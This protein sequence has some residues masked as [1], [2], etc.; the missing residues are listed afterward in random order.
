MRT[1]SP[2]WC[3][4]DRTHLWPT[5]SSL[6]DPL[7]TARNFSSC[8]SDSISRW[9]P[10]PPESASGGFRSALA[11]SDFRLR[12][13]LDVSIPSTSPASEAF[14]PAFGYSAPHP[15]TGGTSTLLINALLSAHHGSICDSRPSAFSGYPRHL[16]K[17]CQ[18]FFDRPSDISTK[19]PQGFHMFSPELQEHSA[20][21]RA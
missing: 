13:R 10:C 11:V 14:N 2:S 19:H 7:I 8:P 9:T 17:F 20:V 4:L 21:S 1:P 12:A 6:G 5:G 18:E 15:S 16:S 3:G